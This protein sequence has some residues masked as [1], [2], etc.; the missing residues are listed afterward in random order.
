MERNKIKKFLFFFD[1]RATFSYS[2]NVIKIF[3]K[4]RLNY[5]ILVSGNYLEKKMKIQKNIF[6]KH[7]LKVTH[8]VNFESPTSMVGS[9]PK[10]FGKAMIDYSNAL[11]KIKPDLIILTGDR[12]ETLCF[13]ITASYM[14]IPIAHIQAGDKSGHIDDLAR[15]SIAKFSHLHF[16]P[17]IEACKRLGSWGE[18][19]KRIFLTGA[20]QLDDIENQL[21]SS[22]N[23]LVDEFL[24][25]Y[26]I[27]I[28]HP[29]LN[30]LEGVNQQISNLLKAINKSKINVKWIYPNNDM[31]YDKI[32]KKII[33]N[34][35]KNI[36]II[37]NY[38]RSDFL[39]ILKNSSGIIG[40]SSSGI[41]EAPSF[42]IPVINIGTRQKGRPQSHNIVNCNYS[43]TE[44]LKKINFIRRNKSFK[45]SLTTVRNLFFVKKSSE[46]IF[47]I[48]KN[49]NKKS[50]LL[51]KY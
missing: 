51:K 38:E 20:P 25:D 8:K 50:D 13:C 18:D 35:N 32:Y 34:K 37:P 23:N 9:W 30:E 47:W 11:S 19:K 29:V 40:N 22:K 27:V 41:I 2:N 7:N 15:A 33:K 12:I 6:E 48:L 26:F 44:I 1:S 43:Y 31:G 36:K 28:F 21:K 10:S 45:K 14:N 46:K 4:N 5:E 49:L 16:A 17:S 24:N 39:N 42:K 3:K